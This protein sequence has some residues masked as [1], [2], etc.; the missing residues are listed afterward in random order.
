MLTAMDD[1]DNI[2][3]GLESGADEY[4]TKP[5]NSRELIARVASGMEDSE[6]SNSSCRP[7]SKWKTLLC[8][9]A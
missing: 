1:K 9:T 3:L 4:L 8:M 7:A 6:A 5:F 2:V